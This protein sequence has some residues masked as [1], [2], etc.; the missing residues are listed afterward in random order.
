MVVNNFRLISDLSKLSTNNLNLI[1][2]IN[3][4][5]KK[6][7]IKFKNKKRR[8]YPVCIKNQII[9]ANEKYAILPSE[10][11]IC[12][13]LSICKVFKFKKIYLI[14]IDGYDDIEKNHE[15]INSLELFKKNYKDIDIYLPQDT[16]IRSNKLNYI[17][18]IFL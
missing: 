9:E 16:Q 8:N 4:F 7:Y 6:F 14:G 12:Y 18:D 17:N 1:A 3:K 11:A 13:A 15:I 5:K 2:P 10:L